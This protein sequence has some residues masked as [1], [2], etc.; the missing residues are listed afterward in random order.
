[1]ENELFEERPLKML[2]PELLFAK[3][4]RIAYIC[5]SCYNKNK[6]KLLE[7]VILK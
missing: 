6:I 3:L 2:R 1:M 7:I 4:M 5:K